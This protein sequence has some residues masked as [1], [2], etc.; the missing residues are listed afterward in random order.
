M[1][2]RDM[3]ILQAFAETA[4]ACIQASCPCVISDGLFRVDVMKRK[5]GDLVVNEF[6]SLEAVASGTPAT[7]ALVTSRL[8]Q[9]WLNILQ[10]KVVEVL[11]KNA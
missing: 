10:R 3:R 11:S 1:G 4:V 7:D 5:C 6:E 9:Y 8:K 2:F